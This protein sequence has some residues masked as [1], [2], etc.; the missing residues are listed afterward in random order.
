[1]RNSFVDVW[2]G[3]IL[4]EEVEQ[5]KCWEMLNEGEREKAMTFLRPELQQKYIKTRG[6]LRKVLS[7]YLNIEPQQIQIKVGQYGKPYLDEYPFHFNL[8]HSKNKFVIA[9]SN[10]SEVG[11]DI[12]EARKRT[13]LAGL[14]DKC[15]SQQEQLF[16]HSLSEQQKIPVFYCFWVR[17]EAFVKAVGRGIALGLDQCVVNPDNVNAFVS[18]PKCYNNASDWTIVDVPIAEN[19]FCALVS[20]TTNY[21]YK[22]VHLT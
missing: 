5:K 20:K 3:D 9:V 10:C 6:I 18:L 14:V 21:E 1:M 12:E 16:W 7:S 13:N 17:K 8:S 11:V 4:T 15:F 19:I 22:Q 2:Y